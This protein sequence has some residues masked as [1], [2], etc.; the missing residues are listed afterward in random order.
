MLVKLGVHGACASLDFAGIQIIM[1]TKTLK[2]PLAC[3]F[4]AAMSLSSWAGLF[5]SSHDEGIAAYQRGDYEAAA[6]NLMDAATRDDPEAYFYLGQLYRQGL[7][8]LT[9]NDD[10]AFRLI[11]ASANENYAPAAMALADWYKTGGGR[12]HANPTLRILWL[13]KA[14]HQNVVAAELQLAKI[15][16]QGEGVLPDPDMARHWWQLAANQGNSEAQ[17][18]LGQLPAP[19]PRE[20]ATSTIQ[21]GG[22]SNN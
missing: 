12:I 3:L 2:R 20:V 14:A 5:G 11:K 15:Y 1:M 18:A 10:S 6:N 9:R 13:E 8:G 21:V 19:S 4:F 22:A 17:Q 16:Q 7:G